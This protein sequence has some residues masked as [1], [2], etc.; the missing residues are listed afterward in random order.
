MSWKADLHLRIVES[1]QLNSS[2]VLTFLSEFISSELKRVGISKAILGLSGGVDSALAASLACAALGPKN[3]T[4][5]YMPYKSSAA[6]SRTDAKAVAAILGMNFREIDISS[7]VDAYYQHDPEA[8]KLRRGNKMARERMSILYDLSQE[9]NSLV[10]GTS[11]KTE[12]LI[13]YGTLYGDMASAINPLG[14]LY[15]TQVWALSQA[16]G[17]P[18]SVLNKAPSADLWAGQSDEA[19]LGFSYFDADRLLTAMIDFRMD[20]ETLKKADFKS[21]LIADIRRRVQR[22]QFKR[23]MPVIA[24]LSSRTLG[25]DFRYPRDWGTVVS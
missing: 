24:K 22:S 6:S 3:V 11:N 1:L 15:K 5:V 2:A 25:R 20:D 14:D 21:D 18:S 19:D 13:G 7:Q 4:A 8:S 9:Q 23:L 10:I 16:A 12:L 17:L